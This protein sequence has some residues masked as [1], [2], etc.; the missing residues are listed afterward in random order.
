MKYQKK[1]QLYSPQ[2]NPLT[3]CFHN[4]I[5]KYYKVAN[6]TESV[7]EINNQK[8]CEDIMAIYFATKKHCGTPK[9]YQELPAQGCHIR[10]KLVYSEEYLYLAFVQL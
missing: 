4:G 10:F 5:S 8:I 2:N 1:L 7:R 9:N 6:L 3:R